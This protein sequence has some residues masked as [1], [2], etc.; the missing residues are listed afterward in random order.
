ML[1]P[2]AAI[3]ARCVEFFLR[4]APHLEQRR[5]IRV[6]HI[7]SQHGVG[8]G[9]FSM[10]A[11]AHVSA[12]IFPQDQ[13]W[14]AKVFWQH[15]GDGVSSRRAEFCHRLFE[16]GCLFPN[17]AVMDQ[18]KEAHR[19][20]KGPR[21]YQ[22]PKGSD[23]GHLVK[24]PAQQFNDQIS[25]EDTVTVEKQDTTQFVE[26]RF[27]RNLD[28]LYAENAK[29]AIRRRIAGSLTANTAL[30]DA[31]A[32]EDDTSDIRKVQGFSL[33]DVYL[34]PTGMSSIFNI[35][36]TLL[37]ARGNLKSICFGYESLE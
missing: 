10:S 6:L 31:I 16:E 5:S 1:F 23:E 17:D 3:A 27:G 36:R 14:I 19:F 21:R 15:T 9:K 7:S 18:L 30:D 4:Q 13:A 8:N 37:S 25:A 32:T 24:V 29:I 11:N 34:Y 26:E 22:R 20:C 12:V 35:H 28:P 33:V 2:S